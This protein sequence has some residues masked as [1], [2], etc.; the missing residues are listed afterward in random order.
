MQVSGGV[1][2]PTRLLKHASTIQAAMGRRH[3]A[4]GLGERMWQPDSG[5]RSEHDEQVRR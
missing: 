3:D 1:V 5:V 2:E 4:Q